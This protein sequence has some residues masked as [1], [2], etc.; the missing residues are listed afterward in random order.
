MCMLHAAGT[1]MFA[2]IQDQDVAFDRQGL[3]LSTEKTKYSSPFSGTSF[4][5][6]FYS[7]EAARPLLSR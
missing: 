6:P 3:Q 7:P 2:A 1:N 4:S 5:P